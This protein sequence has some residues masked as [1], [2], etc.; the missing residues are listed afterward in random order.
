MDLPTFKPAPGIIIVHSQKD[1]TS[2]S[3]VKISNETKSRLVKGTILAMGAH[4][5]TPLGATISPR[6]YGKI[7]DTLYFLSYEGNY[8]NITI[9]T[10]TYYSV[11]F[12]D[13][14]FII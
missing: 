1:D 5:I 13:C 3:R 8:D 11:K 12:E 6:R 9:N 10:E 4:L 14:R 2:S 7:G